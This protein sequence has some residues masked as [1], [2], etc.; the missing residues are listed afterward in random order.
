[1]GERSS[2]S[3]SKKGRSPCPQWT[4][5]NRDSTSK[6]RGGGE[7][8]RQQKKLS[9]RILKKLLSTYGKKLRQRLEKRNGKV[10]K[11]ER[12]QFRWKV[13]THACIREA[14]HRA[15]RGRRKCTHVK[16]IFWA[17]KARQ[18]EEIQDPQE[19]RQGRGEETRSHSPFESVYVGGERRKAL[20][21]HTE[22][23]GLNTPYG[24]RKFR[25]SER[26]ACQQ[27]GGGKVLKRHAS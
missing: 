16:H 1:M 11:R 4:N 5:V 19:R 27:K 13:T 26:P 7:L 24:I 2:Q 8:V 15:T 18:R 20:S 23:G 17:D 3:G 25:G 12:G 14:R 21:G 22:L 9:A 6:Q 10:P